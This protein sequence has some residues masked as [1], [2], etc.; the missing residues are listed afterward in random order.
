MD[1]LIKRLETA[2]R[3]GWDNPA[4]T[5]YGTDLTFTYADIANRIAY[6][7]LLFRE[8]GIQPGDKI[9]LCSKNCSNWAVAILSVITYRAVAV[10]LL[11]D[12]SDEQL[13]MLC[14]HCDAKFMICGTRLAGL[15]PENER[16]MYMYD[17]A[18]IMPKIIS[19]DIDG[20]EA[21]L[22]RR[23]R[24]LYPNGITRDEVCYQ[25][26]NPEDLMLL[27]Y[28]S[29]STG[30]PKGVMLPYRSLWSNNDYAMDALPLKRGDNLLF[31]LPMAHMFGFSYDFL[32]G[33]VAGA[34]MYI[35]TK[36][37]VPSIMLSAMAKVKPV[38]LL[39]VPLVMEKIINGRV[40]PLLATTR[41]KVLLRL[42]VIRGIILTKIRL[43][44]LRAFG[45]N[46][47]AVV[48]GGA[49][50]S[51]EV[52]QALHIIRFPYTVGFGMTECG[53]IITY[54][55]KSVI[56]LGSCGT[57]APRM[58]LKVLSS[59]PQRIPGEIVTRGMNVMT[60]YYKNP[61]ATREIID[62]EGW[63]HTGD[64]GTIDRDG[65]L[66]IRGRK[67][68]ML[69]GADGQNIYPE[70]A[71]SQVVSYTIFDECIV[72][73]RENKLVALVYVSDATLNANGLS[74]QD[75]DGKLEYY[76]KIAN[77]HLPK[78][79]QISQMEQRYEEFEKTPKRS[80][81]R[82]RYE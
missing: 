72:V 70:E 53:P 51:N 79:C 25:E 55:D 54:A 69:L 42:P 50:L 41:M 43:Q 19:D 78:Y 27:S 49:A 73:Q 64:L 62:K 20:V 1:S 28:T 44:L 7:H 80:I 5:D 61:E 23:F 2:F 52:E 4:F 37:P 18:N 14:E 16:P 48:M 56:R 47:N 46:I 71:E 59:D 60:G 17:I 13:M 57:V 31:I 65:F 63:L 11:P 30:N 33:V 77:K 9:A 24:E 34:H 26:E 81:R 35:L 10:P 22:I 66:Y 32:H 8:L 21:K 15:W 40:R 58:E 45:G 12:Y 74:R 36:P 39:C 76:R 82:F 6:M 68:N 3:E 67:K 29:G 38:L 75:V